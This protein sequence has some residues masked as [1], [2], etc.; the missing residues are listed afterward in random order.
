MSDR[1]EVKVLDHEYD[2]IREFDNPLPGW[3]LATFYIMIV[4]TPL[5]I[6]YYHF[7]P[8]KTPTEELSQELDSVK[9][10]QLASKKAEP[11]P[12]EEGLLAIYNDE[13]RRNAGHV[14]Y[15]EKCASCHAPDGG[16]MIGPNLTDKFWIHGKGS[17]VD[18]MQVVGEG[19][20]EK[21]MPPWRPLLKPEEL[22][23]VVAFVKSLQGKHA[24][25][26]KAP[27]GE[28]VKN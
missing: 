5:Y 8:G 28:E 25:S 3:W 23:N 6:G 19:V 10:Q 21:G 27:Q 17:L 24:A 4:F 1:N 18:L 15:T 22:Q 2:G 26:P 11:G 13:G 20:P 9:R 16:G 12:T 7:G 14:V